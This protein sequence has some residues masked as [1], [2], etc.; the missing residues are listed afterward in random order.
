MGQRV[1][2]L[3]LRRFGFPWLPWLVAGLLVVITI[4]WLQQT[5]PASASRHFGK[6]WQERNL[7]HLDRSAKWMSQTGRRKRR[8]VIKGQSR[9]QLY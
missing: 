4:P 7:A 5:I 6:N 9:S 3:S 1:N 2:C 8:M